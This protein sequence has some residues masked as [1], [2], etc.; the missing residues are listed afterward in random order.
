MPVDFNKLDQALDVKGSQ[1]PDSQK[2]LLDEPAGT[3]ILIHSG[4]GGSIGG[5]A[6]KMHL[7]KIGAAFTD[8]DVGC[9]LTLSGTP[10]L[11]NSG[12]FQIIEYVNANYIVYYNLTGIGESIP[13]AVW[14]IN[15]GYTLED[16]INFIRTDRRLIKGTPQHYS[17]IPTYI[18]PKN[19]TVNVS[20]NLTN[21]T[22][23]TLDAKGIVLNRRYA[24]TPVAQ[25]YIKLTLTSIGAMQWA[26]AI[27]RRGIPINDGADAG[28]D[29]STYAEIIDPVTHAN[30]YVTGKAVGDITCVS[31]VGFNDGET[32]VLN[33]GAS[34]AVTFE[35][36]N[37]GSV[38]P[39]PTLRPINYTGLETAA[40]MMTLCIIA[41]NTAPA[42]TITAS[43]GSGSTLDLVND[44][45]GLAGNI[46]ITDTVANP[47][48]THHGM[49]G[50]SAY[51]GN[52]IYGRMQGGAAVEPNS[53]ESAFR[54]VKSSD[55]LSLSVPYFWEKDKPTSIDIYYPYREQMDEMDENALRVVLTS[56]VVVD[57]GL[58]QQII[59]IRTTLGIV[60]GDTSFAGYLTNTSNYYVFSLLDADPTAVEIFNALNAQIGNRS[61]TGT[62]LT[63]GQTVTASLQALSDA[64]GSGP[65]DFDK[66]LI[67]EDWDTLANEDYN[68]LVRE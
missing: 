2:T 50:G 39:T 34:P 61:Y 33:D 20:T 23:K 41:I 13:T 30:I 9:W 68:L 7:I 51:A 5:T 55:P 56:G 1:T 65:V 48:F 64:I 45:P 28:N 6:P 38:I 21:I 19:T 11:A 18:R 66:V 47:S 54:S 24:G 14:L 37:N 53:V 63:N 36:D 12:T 25:G 16:D 22:S 27:D 15:K 32:F 57:I 52:K 43:T 29:L 17:P 3:G 62:V 40:Q 8:Q 46:T 60:Q 35:F 42:L 10:H 58:L 44:T 26:D 49:Y 31:G 59:D 67:N 4:S